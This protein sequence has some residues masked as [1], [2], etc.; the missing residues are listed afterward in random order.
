[1][2]HR[3]F[4]RYLQEYKHREEWFKWIEWVTLTV[5]V[6]SA[7]WE[8]QS[9]FVFPLAALSV[10]YVWVSLVHGLSSFMVGY[11]QQWQVNAAKIRIVVVG[12]S[13]FILLAPLVVLVPLIAGVFRA[14]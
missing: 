5:V 13:P 4:L 1:M 3:N 10:Y 8:T 12:L 14:S 7:W 2:E 6:C 11:L 9:Y